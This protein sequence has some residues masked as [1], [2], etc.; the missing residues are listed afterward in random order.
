MTGC[1]N[2]CGRSAISEIGFIG[3]AAGKYN[4]QLGGDYEGYRLNKTYKE[5]L[6]ENQLLDALDVLFY[7]FKTERRNGEKFGDFSQ[8]KYFVN[9]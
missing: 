5:N 3:T 6:D 7:D 2:G 4:L 1:P 8:R 9:N